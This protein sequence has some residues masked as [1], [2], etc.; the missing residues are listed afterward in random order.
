MQFILLKAM[1][2]FMIPFHPVQALLQAKLMKWATRKLWWQSRHVGVSLELHLVLREQQSVRSKDWAGCP[3][4]PPGNKQGCC[5]VSST[6]CSRAIKG[7]LAFC[8]QLEG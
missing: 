4:R 3:S 8:C 5:S 2:Y 6:P 1:I 7:T